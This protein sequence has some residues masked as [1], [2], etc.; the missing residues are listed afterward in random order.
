M[1]E[2]PLRLR[3]DPSVSRALRED[4]ARA[5]APAGGGYDVAAGLARFEAT[6]R[7]APGAGPGAGV[8]KTVLGAALKGALLG[9]AVVGGAAALGD[10]APLPPPATGAVSA[11]ASSTAPVAVELSPEAP[12]RTPARLASAPPPELAKPV[13][14]FGPAP[15]GPG[16]RADARRHAASGRHGPQRA[17]GGAGAGGAPS[18]ETGARDGLA[19]EMELL[20][21][22]RA[23]Q[24][25]D[26]TQ[27]LAL[28][29]E[30]NRRFPAGLFAQ[31]R[32]AIAIAALVR[33]GR[34]S[35]ARA[36]GAAFLAAYPRSVFAERMKKLTGIG[37]GP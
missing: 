27:A 25:G 1:R 7:A 23:L 10:R 17:R 36:R 13:A 24:N 6:L 19:A 15:A 35:E 20:V 22:L 29:A 2:P 16:A 26:P 9:L 5:A 37:D 18:P 4:L 31:E 8:G 33:L 12:V 11:P 14:L 30:G 21:R 28:A 34:A 3:D 32:E